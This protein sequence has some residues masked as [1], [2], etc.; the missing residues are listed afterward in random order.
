M[1]NKKT[2]VILGVIAICIFG[3]I[4][5]LNYQI[6]RTQNIIYLTTEQ[7]LSDFDML[8]KTLD[9]SYPFWVD[10]EQ[11]G[12]DKDSI[13]KEYRDII[14]NTKTDI[15]FFKNIGYFLNEFKGSG[16]LSAIDGYMYE[17][18]IK[19]LTD[20]ND[21]ITDDEKQNI[22][23]LQ[24]TLENENVQKTYS[25]LDH[26]HKGF[27]STIGLKDKYNEN[28]EKTNSTLSQINSSID[29]DRK[30]AY[31]KIESFNLQ[32]YQNDKKF[33][34]NFFNEIE[35]IPN[36]IIDIRGNSGG[37]DLYWMDLLVKP[38][39][40]E[41]LMSERYFLFNK[42]ELI[43]NYVSSIGL[44]S[45]DINSLSNNLT[46]KYAEFF[47]DYVIDREE[48]K[49]A[50]KPYSGNV[51]VLIDDK[52]YS[53]AENFVMFCKNTEFATLVGTNTNGDGGIADPILLALPNSGLLIR[54]SSFY[55][56]NKDGSGN[57]LNGTQPD[58]VV[59]ENEDSLEK[60]I[61][62]INN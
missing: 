14:K 53:S 7:K 58:I 46:S 13:Y 37:S 23:M 19:A 1:K 2:F 62:L 42:S 22:Q 43:N 17:L 44:V 48:V 25:L 15:E 5:F 40:K 33:L 11:T 29:D 24:K 6:R 54:F 27:R 21:I 61:E 20:S 55:G 3:I 47:T 10:I 30:Y 26:T 8:C 39:A 34:T 35:Q 45:S 36:L 28:E 4:I 60:C 56:L 12:I 41:N 38:N 50:E 49:K 16:H 9:E 31:L 32:N 59:S 18:Y 51:Y 52:V 57:E